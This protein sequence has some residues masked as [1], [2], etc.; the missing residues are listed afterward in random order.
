MNP[1][2]LAE[3][4]N[5]RFAERLR[6]V[7]QARGLTQADL[8]ER[9]GWTDRIVFAI[10]SPDRKRE[11]DLGEALALSQILGVPFGLMVRDEPLPPIVLGRPEVTR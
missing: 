6:M 10:E 1:K 8:G 7:R 5:R 3:A 9:M 4:T 11:A 2:E